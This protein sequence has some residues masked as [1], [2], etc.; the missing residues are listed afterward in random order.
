LTGFLPAYQRLSLYKNIM[1][2]KVTFEIPA[3]RVHVEI[4]DAYDN[5]K[6]KISFIDYLDDTIT[7]TKQMVV[8]TASLKFE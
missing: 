5:G 4:I 8:E 6:S 2:K 3:Q 7:I 1:E